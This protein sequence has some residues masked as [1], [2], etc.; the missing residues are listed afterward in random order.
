MCPAFQRLKRLQIELSDLTLD[1]LWTLD[2]NKCDGWKC[3]KENTAG[4]ESHDEEPD[5]DVEDSE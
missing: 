1:D 5:E 3:V 4:Q 2:L